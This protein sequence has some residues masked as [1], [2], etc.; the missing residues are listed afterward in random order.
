VQLTVVI[1]NRS[2]S[3][4]N[5]FLFLVG[6]SEKK[7]TIFKHFIYKMYWNGLVGKAIN[8]VFPELTFNN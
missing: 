4:T 1:F 8:S 3:S 2:L 5:I 7:N 6:K